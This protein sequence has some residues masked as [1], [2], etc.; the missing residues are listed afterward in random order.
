MNKL[1]LAKELKV[2]GKWIGEN[3]FGRNSAGRWS[4]NCQSFGSYTDTQIVK[5]YMNEPDKYQK[6]KKE[7][8]KKLYI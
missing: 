4:T 2:F 8:Y 1:E 5:M 6:F 7:L 3:N